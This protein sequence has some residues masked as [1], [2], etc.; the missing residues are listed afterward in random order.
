MGMVV[1][2]GGRAES[3]SMVPASVRTVAH[4]QPQDYSLLETGPTG[5]TLGCKT[6]PNFEKE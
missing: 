6:D 4:A 1:D 3:K 2:K 5:S